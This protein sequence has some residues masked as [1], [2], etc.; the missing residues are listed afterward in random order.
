[1]EHERVGAVVLAGGA[2]KRMGSDKA[3]L[4]WN[5]ESML[6]RI[7][8]IVGERCDPVLVLAPEGSPAYQGLRA[9]HDGVDGTADSS[10]ADVTW[11]TGE[12]EGAGPL[13]GLATGLAA[14]AERGRDIV[15][16]CATDMPL[17][18]AEMV[19]ELLRGLTDADDAAIAVDSQ[20]AHPLAGVYRTRAAATL[21]ELV[22]GGERRMLA[23]VDALRTNRV[24]LSDP[25]WLTNVNAPEDLHRLRVP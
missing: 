12:A 15:F 13:G 24:T 14:A 19:D 17:V 4:E 9:G 21:D 5:G 10:S 16:V 1:M 18:T 22:Q 11:V 8:R 23:A 3:A 2:S 20:R 25:T 6:G 7:T